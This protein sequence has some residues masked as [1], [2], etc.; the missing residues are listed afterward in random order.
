MA[1]PYRDG[2][3]DC[4]NT[5]DRWVYF[6]RGFS[7]LE[8]FGRPVKSTQDV[9]GWLS[10]RFGLAGGVLRVMRSSGLPRTKAPR[11][12]DVGVVIIKSEICMGIFTGAVWFTRNQHG[13]MLAHKNAFLRAWS[14]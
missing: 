13:V 5:A 6:K 8:R 4:C 2:E 3:T 1:K 10:E 12:G 11:P 9:D 14:V 7:P